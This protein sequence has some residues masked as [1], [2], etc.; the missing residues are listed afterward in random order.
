MPRSKEKRL[1]ILTERFIKLR[2]SMTQ[3]EFADY[4]GLSRPTVSLY[5][6]GTRIPDAVI[7]RSI[8]EKKNVS[9]DYLLGLRE[10]PVSDK[11]LQF[12]VDYT[13]LS[14]EAIE[15]LHEFAHLQG[16]SSGI[17]ENINRFIIQLYARF[18]HSL[19]MMREDTETGKK[20]LHD[21][22]S[23]KTE[24]AADRVNLAYSMLRSDIF[25]FSEFC[26]EIPDIL[27]DTKAVYS[28]LE[29]RA[30]IQKRAVREEDIA[31]YIKSGEY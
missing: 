11:D 4:L 16:H 29:D 14:S 9:T 31:D 25:H 5:E 19:Q 12:I 8:A 24:A 20:A 13:G 28:E 1:P 2:G 21:F 26:R 6:S 22:T 18:L 15:K 7:L 17:L 3:A 10:D 27:F 30:T 23:E